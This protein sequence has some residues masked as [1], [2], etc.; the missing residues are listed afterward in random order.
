ML[1]RGSSRL[2]L[3]WDAV[4]LNAATVLIRSTRVV[5]GREVIT[6]SPKNRK[7]RLV[8]IGP[9]V[10]A[11]LMALKMAQEVEARDLGPN[12]NREGLVFVN[13]A[14]VPIRPETY[15]GWFDKHNAS[16]GLP[17]IRLHD[18]RHTAATL[19]ASNGVPIIIASGLLGHDPKVFAQVY[20]HLYPD[21]LKRASN[22]LANVFAGAA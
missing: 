8:P 22:A 2:G 20:A 18:L 4:D 7:Q 3:K 11:D 21:D 10:V 1:Q 13:E 9:E 15:S 6:T 12:Y 19:L 14:G 16:A 17:K 5:A